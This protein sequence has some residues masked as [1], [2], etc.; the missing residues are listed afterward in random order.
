MSKRRSESRN[1]NTFNVDWTLVDVTPLANPSCCVTFSRLNLIVATLNPNADHIICNN[2]TT[3]CTNFQE[4]LSA[5]V[6][7]LLLFSPGGK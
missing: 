7:L 4:R 2:K 3:S 6:I 5:K 1:E